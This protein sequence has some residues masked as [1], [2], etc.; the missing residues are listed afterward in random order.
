MEKQKETDKINENI[1]ECWEL[2]KQG[3]EL[4]RLER[5]K[6]KKVERMPL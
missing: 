6:K 5:E 4:K 1:K 3:Y 2:I